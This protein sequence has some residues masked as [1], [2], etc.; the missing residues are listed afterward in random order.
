[1]FHFLF[2]NCSVPLFVLELFGSGSTFVPVPVFVPVMNGLLT[3]GLP[4][5]Y[6][7]FLNLV[8]FWSNLKF[9]N[10]CKFSKS[11]MYQLKCNSIH[12]IRSIFCVFHF[13][14]LCTFTLSFFSITDFEM[15]YPFVC[16]QKMRK[17]QKCQKYQIH[18]KHEMY[19]GYQ[20]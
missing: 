16:V 19:Q 3:N 13:L 5:Y 12:L 15:T 14:H 6:C 11:E 4:F 1:M 20:N 10:S 9:R 18:Q 7:K 17:L 8:T 2:Q